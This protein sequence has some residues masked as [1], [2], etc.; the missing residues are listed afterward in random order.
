MNFKKGF[1]IIRI[2]AMM[3]VLLYCCK[4]MG[5]ER[6]APS[7]LS[8]STR[9]VSLAKGSSEQIAIS[10]GVT[11]YFVKTQPDNAKATASLNSTMLTISGIDTGTTSTILADS[12]VPIADSLE[13]FISILSAL[14]PVSFS[15]Q[16]QPIFNAH[17]TSCHG[18][19]GGLTITAGVSYNNLVNVNAQSSCTA[20]K[21]V[22]PSGAASSV[23]YRKISG[24]SC[25]SQMPQG[26]ILSADD[27]A[28]ISNWINQGANNN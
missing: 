28:V 15:S 13:I 2:A 3:V 19:N 8:A 4:D 10:G 25:G 7:E 16:V 6:S 5:T 17:C 22:L 24:T 21:R 9:N 27:I 1:S 11:P 12:K 18:G 14:P 26:S 20:L 23:L